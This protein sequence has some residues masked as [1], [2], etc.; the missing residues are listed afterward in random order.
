MDVRQLAALVAVADHG[1][2]SAAARS[3]FTVQSNVSGHIAKLE[4]ELGATL[5]DRS[6]GTLT[7]EGSQ[8]VERARR[9]LHEL[10]DIA[11]DMASRHDE[12]AGDV[13]VGVIGTTARWLIP[14]FLSSMAL[15]HPRVRPVVTDGSTSTILPGLLTGQLNAAIIHLPVDDPELTVTP[16]FA[17]E[18]LVLAPENHQLAGRTSLNLGDLAGIPV[19]LPPKGTAFRRVIDR[20]ATASNT[21][22]TAQAEIDGV[23]LLASLAIDGYGPTIVPATAVPGAVDHLCRIP[24]EGLPRRVVGW[25]RRRKPRPS[26]PTQAAEDV[27]RHTVTATAADQPGVFVSTD[28][29]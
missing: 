25:A 24:V 28:H 19:L 22:L 17:E 12:V 26:A 20:A 10:D 9:I 5:V 29:T 13:R 2:F 21:T 11:S 15:E 3:L 27:L 1:T 7:D 14:K 4:R 23:R 8:V 16:L 6:L 18:M